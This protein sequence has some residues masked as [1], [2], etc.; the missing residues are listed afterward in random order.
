MGYRAMGKRNLWEVYRRWRAGQSVSEIARNE[1]WDR[2]TVRGYLERFASVGL[3]QGGAGVELPRFMELMAGR[4]PA[5]VHPGAPG[6]VQL[7]EHEEQLR[8]LINRKEE[9][10]KPKSAFLV[11][12]TKYELEVSY[13]TF[14]RFARQQRL[15]RKERRQMI[16]I[17]LP[18]GLETQ[19][20]YGHVGTLADPVSGKDRAVYAYC[21][22]L[23]FSR[24]PHIEFVRTQDASSFA[25]SLVTLVHDYEGATEW[26]S[27]DNLKAGVIKPDLWDPTI[28]RAL[29]EVAA[30]YKIFVNPCRVRRSTD[31]GKVERT[32]PL[33]RELFR[34]LKELHPTAGLVELNERARVWCR[35]V[36]GRKEHGTTGVPPLEAFEQERPKLKA[37]PAERYE[38]AVW[39]QVTVHPGDQ[40]LSF[41]KRRFSLPPAWKGRSL[42][43][44]YAEPL[45]ALYDDQDRTIRQYVVRPGVYRYW[46]P[47]DFP[48]GVREMMDG[49]YPAWL[50]EKAGLYGEA[51]TALIRSVLRPHA[52]L[53]ARRARGMLDILAAHHGKPYFPQV[54]LRAT[55]RSVSL[56]A[57]L[58]RMMEAAEKLPLWQSELPLSSTGTE[59]VRDIHYYVGT[60]S[61]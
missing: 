36:Y 24:L 23:A 18:P 53:N 22:V 39:K 8:K 31:K 40:F 52:Y 16:R 10:L 61:C 45:L 17:E 11:V 13:E 1:G 41:Q 46:V 14:K 19:L 59:M 35:E 9:P 27:I 51:A 55:R 33:A 38:V 28:N 20:D 34:M 7:G 50:I 6:R 12:K 37:I 15:N 48:E 44:R 58:R 43:A 42:W 54:C 57:T 3:Q 32:V 2:K 30:H 29:A 60:G 47:E 25:T 26:V 21:G 5:R 56:P 49:G 4:I